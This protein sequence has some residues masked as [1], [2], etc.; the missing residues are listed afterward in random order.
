MDNWG[1]MSKTVIKDKEPDISIYILRGLKRARCCLNCEHW[2]STI[3]Q[4][5]HPANEKN[6]T[7]KEN[8]VCSG[9]KDIEAV[10][11][12]SSYYR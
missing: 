11:D 7:I 2:Y 3:L 8:M 5:K 1:K 4:C 10:S 9:F 6:F 12:T